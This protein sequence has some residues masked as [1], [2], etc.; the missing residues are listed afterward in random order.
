MSQH[1]AKNRTA[2][3]FNLP[4]KLVQELVSLGMERNVSVRQFIREAVQD[5]ARRSQTEPTAKMTVVA[6]KELA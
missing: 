3:T 2:V 6:E 5:L 1:Q 4:D